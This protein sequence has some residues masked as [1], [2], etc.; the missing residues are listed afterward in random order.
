MNIL[1]TGGAGFIGRRLA[2]ALLAQGAIASGDDGRR[3]PIERIVLVDHVEGPDLADPRVTA[4][5]G[6]ICDPALMGSLVTPEVGLIFHLAAVVS[7]AAEADFDL[8]MRINLDASRQLLDLARSAGHQPRVVF[9]SSVAVYGGA[10]PAVVTDATPLDPRSSYGAQKAIG[11]F[12]LNDYTRKGFVDGR[13]LRLPTISVRP[14]K[15]NKAASSFA[16]SIIREPLSG[17][18]AVCPVPLDLTL[19]LASPRGV[20][21][22]IVAG[23]QIPSAT[24]G[25]NR[26]LNLPGLSVSVGEMIAALERAQPGA[27]GRIRHEPDA[28]I[29]AIVGSWPGAWDNSRALGLGLY[30]D[31]DF[32]AIVRAYIE[33]DLPNA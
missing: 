33:D 15:P 6:D 11:E 31:P 20:V 32:D 4:I 5:A 26:A 12:L 30:P 9:T 28:V 18:A 23:A 17:R 14:G 3:E 22:N 27:S 21:A 7:G 25:A 1:I 2:K 29:S 19:W 10:L 24:L 16:S 8:G 13:I